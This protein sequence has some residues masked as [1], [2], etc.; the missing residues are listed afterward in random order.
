VLE[1]EWPSGSG[2]SWPD[3]SADL[4]LLEEFGCMSSQMEAASF[5][6]LLPCLSTRWAWAAALK[7]DLL[8]TGFL[9]HGE[10]FRIPLLVAE[11]RRAPVFHCQGED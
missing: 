6:R 2:T 9:S 8:V 1:A 10:I 4:Q 7:W 3:L 11:G 5:P